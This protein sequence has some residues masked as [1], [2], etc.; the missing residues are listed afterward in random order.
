MILSPKWATH[1]NTM[2]NTVSSEVKLKL[3][4][5]IESVLQISQSDNTMSC[6][7]CNMKFKGTTNAQVIHQA[8]YTKL[9][10]AGFIIVIVSCCFVPKLCT[11]W[12]ARRK[13]HYREPVQLKFCKDLQIKLAVHLFSMK[14]KNLCSVGLL[15][16]SRAC[17]SHVASLLAIFSVV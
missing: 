2:S 8:A 9:L 13:W 5:F 12:M 10:V 3:P 14:G 4:T 7:A 1:K 6:F 15:W 11:L 17:R 16:L